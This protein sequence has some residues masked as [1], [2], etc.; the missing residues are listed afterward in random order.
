MD[1]DRLEWVYKDGGTFLALASSR[2]N[3]ING[4]RKWD[5]AFRVYAIIYCGAHPERAKEIWQYVEIIHTAANSFLWENVASYDYTFRQLMAFN[6]MRSW[7]TTYN[8]MWNI[9]MKDPL[10][11][12]R[13]NS[14]RTSFITGNKSGS[15]G[16]NGGG[17]HKGPRSKKKPDYCWNFNKG[18]VCRY[19]N[20][21]RFIERCSYCDSPS[22]GVIN[23]NK[24]EKK[25]AIRL[26][27]AGKAGSSATH[28]DAETK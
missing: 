6:P 26:A 11:S 28:Q 23:C 19:G 18:L 17:G 24:L 20:R 5:Q 27:N 3:R 21:C 25:E 10:A 13:N 22:H 12:N 2:E 9:C 1:D 8:Q 16:N 15:N 7:A 14:Q 4:I